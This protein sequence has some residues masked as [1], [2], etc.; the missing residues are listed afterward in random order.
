MSGQ[1]EDQDKSFDPTPNKLQEARKKGEVAKSTDLMTAAAY[2]GLTVAILA[3][4]SQSVRSFGTHAMA[5][6]EQAEQISDQIFTGGPVAATSGWIRSVA[7]DLGPLFAVPSLAVLAAVLAQ[8]AFVVAPSKLQPKLS[9]ISVL[10]N[11]KQKFGRSG[12]FE[13]AKSFSKLLIFSACLALFLSAKLPEMISVI[14]NAPG[15][16]V[17]L[18]ADLCIKFLFLVV[19][20]S[21]IIGSIDAVWQHHEHLRKN[22]MSRKEIMDENKSTEGDPHLKQERRS[23]A[24]AIASQQMMSDVPDADV[25]IVNPTHFAVAL[26]WSRDTGTAPVC[27]AKGLDEIALRIREVAMEAGVP[28]HHDP[29]TARALHA[30]TE[31]GAEVPPD[32][33]QAV[34]AAIRFA[35]KLRAQ[36]RSGVRK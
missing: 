10:Q 33:Y 2:M 20:V 9:R 35:D 27:V 16:V 23:R 25:I 18:L 1:D 12:L 28:I 17:L 8:R 22:R 4:G 19:I 6:L 11:A 34:A 31:I 7:V 13:F 29:P 24:Q 32:H 21:F 5:M 30:V 26:K 15:G 36:V 3:L 14:H